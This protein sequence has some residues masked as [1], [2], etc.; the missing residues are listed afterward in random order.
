MARFNKMFVKKLFMPD[1]KDKGQLDKMTQ[2]TAT[3]SEINTGLDGITSTAAELNLL[4]GSSTANAVASKAVILNAGGD[5]ITASNVGTAGTGVTAVEYGDGLRHTTVLT[6]AGVI[7]AVAGA[8]NHAEG[9]VVYTF[10]TSG[11]IIINSCTMSIG[12]TSTGNALDTPEV[13]IG[14]VLANDAQATLGAIGATVENI[15]E[16]AAVVGCAGQ[17]KVIADTPTADYPFVGAKGANTLNLNYAANWTGAEAAMAV[18][19]TIIVDW[20]IQVY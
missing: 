9:L 4:D 11:T 19:G 8:G 2:V 7:A 16:G 3:A 10:P 13:G 6:V 20:S 18:A 17:V 14:T 12:A 1:G 15:I 5:I